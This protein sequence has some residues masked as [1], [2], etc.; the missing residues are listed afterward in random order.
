[1]TVVGR[2]CASFP[3]V[4]LLRFLFVLLLSFDSPTMKLLLASALYA[5][6]QSQSTDATVVVEGPRTIG[7]FKPSVTGDGS[8]HVH[9]EPGSSGSMSF[10]T[11]GGYN[12]TYGYPD[13]IGGL[14]TEGPFPYKNGPLVWD[15][16]NNPWGAYG[17][18]LAPGILHKDGRCDAIPSDSVF[19]GGNLKP[20]ALTNGLKDCMLGCNISHVSATGD[21][22]CIIG[23]VSDTTNSPMRCY[24]VGPGF[25]GGWGVCGYNCT[26]FNPKSTDKLEPCNQSDI[27]NC[28]IYCDSRT[29]PTA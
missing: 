4:Q 19:S 1:M 7:T 8:Q 17:L 6:L 21:D 26:V 28:Y 9:F 25:A 27:G 18:I 2:L 5:V 15:S 22:P 24:D 20:V 13:G 29:F 10:S 11:P 23:S 3:V 12:E 16:G 14:I